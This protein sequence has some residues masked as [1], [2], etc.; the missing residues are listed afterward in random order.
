MADAPFREK[1][2]NISPS[3]RVA[4]DA[5]QAPKVDAVE[6]HGQFAGAKLD[7]LAAACTA[8]TA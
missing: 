2:K 6:E 1:I 5:S 4:F 7:A 8:A 3:P